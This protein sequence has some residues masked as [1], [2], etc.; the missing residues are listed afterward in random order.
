MLICPDKPL[1]NFL[2]G[3]MN[4]TRNRSRELL[5]LGWK[6]AYK[7]MGEPEAVPGSLPVDELKGW[8]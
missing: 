2:F 7:A 8:R 3:T 5:E 4:F 6:D 1:G